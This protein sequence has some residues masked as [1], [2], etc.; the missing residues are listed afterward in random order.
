MENKIYL[1]NDRKSAGTGNAEDDF[2]PFIELSLIETE[3]PLGLVIVLPGGGYRTRAA[4]EGMP[5]AKKFNELGFHAAVAPM[6]RH[7]SD[8]AVVQK[9]EETQIASVDIGVA[10]CEDLFSGLRSSVIAI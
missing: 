2:Q 10:P 5:I 7:S 3:T 4:H 9:G 8:S 6:V 1:W